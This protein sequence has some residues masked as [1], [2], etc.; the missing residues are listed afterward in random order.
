ME[1]HPIAPDVLRISL[2]KPDHTN[3]YLVGDI[4]IDAGGRFDTRRVLRALEGRPVSAHALT[5]AHFDHTGGS[6]G[7][8]RA[9]GI[10]LWCGSGD[11]EAVES[12]DW[13][14]VLPKPS[15]LLGKIHRALGRAA[16]PVARVLKEGDEVGGFAVVET[17]GHTPGHLAY[18]R[19]DDGVLILGD[20]A[21][22]RNPLTLR[23][24]LTE[25]FP[26]ATW[27][28]AQNRDSA[29]KLAALNPLTVCFGHGAHLTEG[30]RFCEFVE[31]LP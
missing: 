5:H 10:P 15:G 21:F 3:V 18:W 2:L 28:P 4:L 6:L 23:S 26:W 19:E 25:P 24:G 11:R 17:P 31:G 7:V 14:L 12:G 22:H 8:C 1:I 27:D 16:G 20:V 13:S 29:R 9:L 30:R